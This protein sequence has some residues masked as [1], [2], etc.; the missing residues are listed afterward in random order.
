MRD[1]QAIH[2]ISNK[3][4]YNQMSNTRELKETN[5]NDHTLYTCTFVVNLINYLHM[6]Q[7][8]K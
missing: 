5:L 2:K 8:Y 7:D 6:S 1:L 3:L 4:A